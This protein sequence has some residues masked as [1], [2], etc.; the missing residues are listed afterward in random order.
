MHPVCMYAY[1]TIQIARIKEINEPYKLEI[2]DSIKDDTI[3]I[4]HIGDEWWDLCSGPHV[5]T[6]GRK[7]YPALSLYTFDQKKKKKEYLAWTH[8]LI[9]T[10]Q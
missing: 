4:Y 5:E 6:T 1:E 8:G 2:L 9:G 7:S 10:F 3:T